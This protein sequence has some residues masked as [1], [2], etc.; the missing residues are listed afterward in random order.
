MNISLLDWS[1]FTYISPTGSQYARIC[2]GGTG[3]RLLSYL[4][5]MLAHF[6]F[7]DGLAELRQPLGEGFAFN[8]LIC[9][10]SLSL[11]IKGVKR[12]FP[13]VFDKS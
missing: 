7:G 12:I 10:L 1:Y 3:A 2:L 4:Y 5:L 13:D 11:I 8:I 6:Y 9:P